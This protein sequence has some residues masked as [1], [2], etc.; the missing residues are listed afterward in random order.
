M[1]EIKIWILHYTPLNNRKMHMINQLDKRKANYTFVE[2]Y[3]RENMTNSPYYHKVKCGRRIF[4]ARASN[5]LKTLHIFNEMKQ[6]TYKYN[7]VMEDDCILE[8]N[9]VDSLT[10]SLQQLPTNY[11]ILDLNSGHDIPQFRD[12]PSDFKEN[13]YVYLQAHNP[14]R[15]YLKSSASYL[16]SRDFINKINQ[17]IDNLTERSIRLPTD[18]FLD[19]FVYNNKLNVYWTYPYIVNHGSLTDM[20]SSTCG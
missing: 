19:R 14:K 16:V 4:P 2:V 11:H 3:D 18:I 9:F 8:N 7:M 5:I 13:K 10:K 6:S 1:D 17:Y 15:R 12:R 20:F